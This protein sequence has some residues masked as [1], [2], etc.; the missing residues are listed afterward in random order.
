MSP[1]TG[2]PMTQRAMR[3]NVVVVISPYGPFLYGTLLVVSGLFQLGIF[4]V[5]G[6][7]WEGPLSWRKSVTSSISFRLTASVV[8]WIPGFLELGGRP[9]GCSSAAS[10]WPVATGSGIGHPPDSARRPLA[11]RECRYRRDPVQS[12]PASPSPWWASS[13]D[14]QGGRLPE[15]D[16]PSPPGVNAPSLPLGQNRP[17]RVSRRAGPACFDPQQLRRA[18]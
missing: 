10:E 11:L 12:P 4:L 1:S 13:C 6:G 16:R 14:R 15:A 18:R 2:R 17:H 9:E 5:N 8:A 3:V 7:P